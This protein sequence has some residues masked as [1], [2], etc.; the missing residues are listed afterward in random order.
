M[1]GQ[2]KI[3]NF[4]GDIVDNKW[5]WNGYISRENPG[6]FTR[7]L[8]QFNDSSKRERGLLWETW[9]R[10]AMCK[11]CEGPAKDSNLL[12]VKKNSHYRTLWRCLV[13]TA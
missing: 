12:N 13:N 8:F 5:L 6:H 9:L 4:V 1:K 11:F 3:M 7:Q 2:D 10:S